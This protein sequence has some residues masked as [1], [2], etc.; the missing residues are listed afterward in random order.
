MKDKRRKGTLGGSNSKY[1][2]S[3][4][5]NRNAH[6]KEADRRSVRLEGVVRR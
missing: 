5:G 2:V 4:I 1:K 3:E 6:I